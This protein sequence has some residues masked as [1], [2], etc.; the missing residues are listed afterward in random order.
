MLVDICECNLDGAVSLD[1]QV[2]QL[3][4]TAVRYFVQN[5]AS[6]ART[7][8]CSNWLFLLLFGVLLERMTTWSRSSYNSYALNFLPTCMFQLVYLLILLCRYTDIYANTRTSKSCFTIKISMIFDG[9]TNQCSEVVA[10]H[11][12]YTLVDI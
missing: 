2:C 12:N 10:T 6:F 3:L 11:H 7:V 8:L 9:N 5:Q 1:L 4:S